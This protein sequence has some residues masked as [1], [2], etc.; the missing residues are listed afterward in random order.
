[1]S[2]P[3]RLCSVLGGLLALCLGGCAATAPQ[4]SAP[5]PDS[6]AMA[7]QAV[8]TGVFTDTLADTVR[9]V[10]RSTGTLQYT[11]VELREPPQVVVDMPDARLGDIKQPIPVAGD[12]IQSIEPLMLPD[13][14]GVRLLLHLQRMAAHTVEVQGPQLLI[15]LKAMTPLATEEPRLGETQ[16]PP[17][18]GLDTPGADRTV[19][20]AVDFVSLPD[21]SIILVHTTGTPPKVR[22][23]QRQNPLRL[24]LDVEQAWLGAGQEKTVAVSDPGGVVTQLLAFQF[25]EEA[26]NMVKVVAHLR[27]PAPF[28]VQQDD[29]VVRLVVATSA[30]GAAPGTPGLPVTGMSSSAAAPA[31]TPQGAAP[32]IPASPAPAPIAQLPPPTRP[33][34]AAP[35][36]EAEQVPPTLGEPQAPQYTGQKISLDFQHADINDILRLLAE[37]SGLNIIAGSDVQGTITTHMVDVPW[38]Q[39]LDVILRI[40]GLAQEREGNIIRVAPIARFIT[41]RQETLRVRQTEVQAE[42]T[43]TQLVPINYANATEL[44]GNLDKLLSSR[45]S[46]IIDPRTNTMI[47]TDTR[48]NLD[49]MLALV[50]T[51]DRQ[52]SQVMIETRIVE[53]TRNF[54]RDL[55]I[56]LGAK[57][58]RVTDVTFPNR[59]GVAGSANPSEAGNFLV[60]LPAAVGAGS[61]GAISFAL[62]GASSLIDLRLSAAESSGQVKI[63]SNPKIATLDNA[64]ALI[65]SG[66]RIP[67]QTTSAEGTRTELIDANL[68]LKVTPHV[69]QDDF[70]SMKLNA[71]KNEPDFG[72]VVNGVPTITTR[73]ASTNMLVRDGDT[74]VI[75]GLYRRTLSTS[76]AGVPWVSQVPVLGWFFQKTSE[77]D[78][79]E[80]LIIFLTPRIIRQPE[81]PRRTSMSGS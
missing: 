44:K 27:A 31:P 59:I 80:E 73:E 36:R 10:V 51:L 66:T 22:V 37:V 52:T 75:G 20:T 33:E 23:R 79:N 64:E 11:A 21:Q 50:E 2:Y 57:Y 70:I 35:V 69:T 71:T 7:P 13:V 41:E 40:N 38:D 78:T 53:A 48:K 26:E 77:T 39:A 46:I 42:P 76:R 58:T 17:R 62:A 34:T 61:G 1:V 30:T 5:M 32:S 72:R 8:I 74:V 60:D 63:I 14:R 56:Q 24:S 18:T 16:E 68:S 19:V 4:T 12:L 3:S 29:S 25:A 54:L 81:K 55:G 6:Q 45:G 28:E 43:I 9:V 67:V 47:I 65:Q 15:V 49:D